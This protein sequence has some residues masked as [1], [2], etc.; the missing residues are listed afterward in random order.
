[1][2]V[3]TVKPDDPSLQ[4]PPKGIVTARAD[5]FTPRHHFV[6]TPSFFSKAGLKEAI[7]R[8]SNMLP[9]IGAGAGGILAGGLGIPTG[10]G[11]IAI[12][13]GGAAAG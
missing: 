5:E 8:Y 9:A 10:L 13:T 4:L 2:P 12:A 7:G 11:D 3:I 1:M 6:A